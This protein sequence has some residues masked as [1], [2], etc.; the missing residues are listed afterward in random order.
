MRTIYLFLLLTLGSFAVLTQGCKTA[1]GRLTKLGKGYHNLTGRYNAYYHSGLRVTKAHETITEQYR[2][3]YN[4]LLPLYT[5]VANTDT[6]SIKAPLDEAIRKL[7]LNIELHRPGQWTDDSYLM[8]GEIEFLKRNYAK[9]AATF[10]YIVDKYNPDKPR[11]AMDAEELAEL[12]LKQAKENK[13]KKKESAKKKKKKKKKPAKKPSSKKKKKKKKPAPKPVDKTKDGGT[14]APDPEKEAEEEEP[15][16]KKTKGSHKP[17]RPAAMLWLAKSLIEM[18]QYSEAALYLRLLDADPNTPRK[19]RSE[20]QAVQAHLWIA[21]KEYT[22]AIEPLTKAIELCKK[23]RIKSRY[24]YVLAQLHERQNNAQLAYESYR[25]VVK[26]KPSY[27][28]DL[29]ARLSMAKMGA[30]AGNTDQNP[31]LALRRML[32]EE[33]NEEYKDQIYF[34]LAEV[35]LR[36]GKKEEGI[37]S[38]Q[39][40]MANSKGGPQRAE[41]SYLL[42]TLYYEA[43]DYVPA[44]LYADSA[45][46]ALAKEDPRSTDMSARKRSLERYA[47]NTL[48]LTLNDSLLALSRLPYEEQKAYA[49][50]VRKAQAGIVDK[51]A[52]NADPKNKGG[53]GR[54]L[55]I[56]EKGRMG[57]LNSKPDANP[58]AKPSVSE[59]ALNTSP[60]PLYNSQQQKRG[61]KEFEK[62]FGNRAWADNWRSAKALSQNPAI[63]AGGAATELQPMTEQETKDFLVKLGIPQDEKQQAELEKKIAI[64]L[65]NIGSAQ[66]EDL[67]ETDKALAT[68]ETLYT[69]FPKSPQALE[70]LYLMFNIYT[71]RGDQARAEACKKRI[72]DTH[73]TSDIAKTVQNPSFLNARQQKEK[74]LNQFYEATYEDVQRRRFEEAIAKIAQVSQRFGEQHT[75]R[76]RFALLAAMC[77]GGTKGEQDYIKALKAVSTSFPNTEEDKK[78][79]EIVAALAKGGST[80][81]TA[82]TNKGSNSEPSGST[83]FTEN[84]NSGHYILIVFKDQKTNVEPFRAPVS[85]F[86]TLNYPSARLNVSGMAIENKIPSI[87]IRKFINAA[88]ALNYVKQAQAAPAFLGENAP[89]HRIL[90]IQQ[91]NYRLILQPPYGKFDAYIEFHDKFYK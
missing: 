46:Q 35:Q 47:T 9:S 84:L 71:Q 77:E 14:A 2:D 34:A 7:A 54:P 39:A 53:N 89:E 63:A 13:K 73:P 78:A 64:N 81:T 21:Q 33:K 24:V 74:E 37:A 20:I 68:L 42:A 30:K 36:N 3:N 4:E 6:N 25:R 27:E 31:E 23:R 10:Q 83:K 8:L 80:T 91:D 67:A 59:N 76:P 57:G 29:N 88:D 50:R 32:R 86:N 48:A 28:M 11:S 52:K 44:Y 51:D 38:L 62:R 87:T 15:K 5:Y 65:L 26:L 12:K 19:L 90:V 58:S 72:L 60:F 79:K 17:A 1:D 22:K 56:E 82:E 70:G 45:A 40:S 66:H 85:E 75:F 18:K 41:A 49:Q 61:E 16:P 43:K 69:R 55:S